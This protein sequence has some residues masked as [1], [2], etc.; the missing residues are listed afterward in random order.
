[1]SWDKF[2]KFYDWEFQLFCQ[3]QQN[4]V[5]LWLELAEYHGD[6]ILELACGSGRITIPLA[7]K[8]YQ[9][10]ALDNSS[11]MLQLLKS[12][13]FEMKNIT[14]VKASMTN[15]NLST[16]YNF[17]LISYSSF[18]Q[19]LSREDQIRCLKTIRKHLTEKGVLGLDIGTQVCAGKDE[20]DYRH[21]YTAEFP[22][23]NSTVSMF[24]SY[25]TDH[26]NK[27]RYWKDKYLEVF[28]DGSSKTYYNQIALKEC[29]LEYMQRLFKET[30]FG[31]VDVYGT[32]ERGKFSETS[33]NAIYLVRKL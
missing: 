20:T 30:G 14:A 10:T 7:Q 16:K 3:E 27:I 1:M 2:S 9:I 28:K 5:K 19:L 31:I 8:G 4:D 18:Q 6:P 25:K 15:F 22:Q 11:Q 26:K 24:T 23:N 13:A 21:L 12:K 33:N 29:G 32:F 17:A